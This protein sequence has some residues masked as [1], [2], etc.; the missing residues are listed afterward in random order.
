MSQ[1]QGCSQLRVVSHADPTQ[2]VPGSSGLSLGPVSVHLGAKSQEHGPHSTQAGGQVEALV[3]CS[4]A[5]VT[6]QGPAIST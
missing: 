6:N 4:S 2:Q 3:L 1:L 5:G